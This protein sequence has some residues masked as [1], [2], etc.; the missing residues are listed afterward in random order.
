[1]GTQDSGKIVP[2]VYPRPATGGAEDLRDMALA[3]RRGLDT[4]EPV[5]PRPRPPASGAPSKA[6]LTAPDLG[7]AF[8]AS[9]DDQICER[10]AAQK[11]A[12]R[13]PE[14]TDRQ[15]EKVAS[16]IVEMLFGFVLEDPTLPAAAKGILQT[17]QLPT[18]RMAFRDPEFFA[19]WQHPARRLLSDIAPLMGLHAT[20][21]GDSAAFVAELDAGVRAL[22]DEMEPR[23]TGYAMLGERLRTFAES[24]VVRETDTAGWGQAEAVA[25]SFLER[26][27][28]QLARDFVAGYWI[29]VLELVAD[30]HG[31]DS[32][33]WQEALDAIEDLAWSLTPKTSE[34][35]RYRLIEL[36]PALLT[37]L[38]RGLDLIDVPREDRRP[39]FDALIEI[40]AAMLQIETTPVARP[41][42][43][44]QT[45]E[46]QVALLQRGDWVEFRLDD[47][48]TH[49]ERLNWISPQR[50]ILVFSN[51]QGQR[52]IQI[53]PEDLADLVRARQA[54]LIFDRPL[55]QSGRDS[56]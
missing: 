41:T 19:D 46:E 27:L 33:H 10:K 48:S 16:E 18:L 56:A 23:R 17:A 26:P 21:G 39:F 36:V 55:S 6:R 52:A 8:I 15:I 45:A 7:A 47:G 24:A 44:P 54:T 32:P 29:D 12:D 38:N 4:L 22:L 11:I 1:M 28:P 2:F 51:R 20:R 37:R 3:R 25:R 42:V 30:A 49:R 34:D 5:A 53:A 31:A 9:L 13:W 14:R 43:L 50:G 40:H 35:D